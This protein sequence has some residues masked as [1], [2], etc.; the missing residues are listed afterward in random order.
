MSTLL[1]ARLLLNLR[2]AVDKP[3]S[4]AESSGFLDTVHP[5]NKDK[6]L[7]FAK[8]VSEDTELTRISGATRRDDIDGSAESIVRFTAYEEDADVQDHDHA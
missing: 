7:V 6:S 3:G 5:L 2:K 8:V 1:L 4:T